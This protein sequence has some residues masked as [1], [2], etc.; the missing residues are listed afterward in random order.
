MLGYINFQETS[1]DKEGR[2]KYDSG[3]GPYGFSPSELDQEIAAYLETNK[4]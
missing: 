3:L 2:V 4:G 1:V